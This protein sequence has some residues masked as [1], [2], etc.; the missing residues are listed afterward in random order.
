MLNIN[1]VFNN[2][3]VTENKLLINTIFLTYLLAIAR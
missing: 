1:W 2:E 3:L